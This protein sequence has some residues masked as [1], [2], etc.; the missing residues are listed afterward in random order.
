MKYPSTRFVCIVLKSLLMKITIFLL[1]FYYNLAHSLCR[2]FVVV[3]V[4]SK[5][6]L[7]PWLLLFCSPTHTFMH[8]AARLIMQIFQDGRAAPSETETETST[9]LRRSFRSSRKK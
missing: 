3:H 1:F 7:Y 5:F 6:Q 2:S 9:P 8:P 4:Y